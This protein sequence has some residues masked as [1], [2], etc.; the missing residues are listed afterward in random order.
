[1]IYPAR[2]SRPAPRRVPSPRRHSP[3][4]PRPLV[5]SDPPVPRHPGWAG[6]T[7]VAASG[8]PS[9]RRCVPAIRSRARPSVPAR[10]AQRRNGAS[11]PPAPRRRP[12]PRAPAVDTGTMPVPASRRR[13]PLRRADRRCK[14]G[15]NCRT[16]RPALPVERTQSWPDRRTRLRGYPSRLRG[17]STH[18]ETAVRSPHAGP[19]LAF[20]VHSQGAHVREALAPVLP[21][22]PSLQSP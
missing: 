12:G 14:D 6:R 20:G 21:P 13:S 17:L 5:R 15:L 19:A 8:G 7:P 4:P 3:A 2:R 18:P 1:V 16:C 11:G 10:L 9:R 22:A